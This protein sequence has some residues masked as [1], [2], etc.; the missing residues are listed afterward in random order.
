[1]LS[2]TGYKLDKA[3]II[4]IMNMESMTNRSISAEIGRRIEQIRLEQNLT[5]QQV[6]DEI[7]LSRVSYRSLVSNGGK[8]ENIIAT[9]R[10]LGRLD[11]I[12][13]FIPDT[14]FSPMEQL[15]L[16]GKKRKRASGEHGN[17]SEPNNNQNNQD[18]DW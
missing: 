15:K 18:L 7:G 9:L 3:K 13:H 17:K 11:L 14:T 10:V 8:F 6:A 16:Q 12:E 5:Q 2:L 1:M 4:N